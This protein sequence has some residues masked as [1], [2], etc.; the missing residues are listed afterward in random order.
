MPVT[1]VV[2]R[3]G[4]DRTHRGDADEEVLAS[5][6][7]PGIPGRLDPHFTKDVMIGAICLTLPNIIASY[8]VSSPRSTFVCDTYMGST[9]LVIQLLSVA[10]DIFF[11]QSI[12]ILLQRLKDRGSGGLEAAPVLFGVLLLVSCSV[13]ER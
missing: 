6:K 4:L 1:L 9:V 8:L 11:L 10:L 2:W 13:R 12:P 5:F 3:R 7:L